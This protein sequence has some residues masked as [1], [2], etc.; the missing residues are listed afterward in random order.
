M[1]NVKNIINNEAILLVAILKSKDISNDELIEF[2][3]LADRQKENI[4]SLIE[5]KKQDIKEL[6]KSLQDIE[7]L[8]QEVEYQK[9]IPNF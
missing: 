3:I 5:E 1:D 7:Y 6:E 8:Q 4:K 2:K 9:G